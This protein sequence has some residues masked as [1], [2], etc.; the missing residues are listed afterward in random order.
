NY[1][2]IIWIKKGSG[3][4][5]VDFAEYDLHEGQMF[6]LSPYQPY[7]FEVDEPLEGVV[8]NF[9][10]DFFCI[11]RHQKEVDCNGVLFHN[12]YDPPML[13]VPEDQREKFDELA[14]QMKKEILN[15]A[16]AQNELLVSL[17]KIWLVYASRIKAVQECT[18]PAAD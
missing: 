8:I 9:H 13:Q 16:L 1:Y 11:Y 2:S 5:R 10:P 3:I 18:A 7:M 14:E 4:A 17:L 12:I 6:F 15:A